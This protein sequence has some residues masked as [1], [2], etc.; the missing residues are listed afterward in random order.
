MCTL[1][2]HKR[3][4]SG[5]ADPL[6][7]FYIAC[8]SSI[9]NIHTHNFPHEHGVARHS[10]RL[11]C[12]HYMIYYLQKIHL[13]RHLKGWRGGIHFREKRKF[14]EGTLY[15]CKL[16]KNLT[17]VSDLGIKFPDLQMYQIGP[18]CSGHLTHL[19]PEIERQIWS[20]LIGLSNYIT[21]SPLLFF[22]RRSTLNLHII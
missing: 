14:F 2:Y 19:Y 1:L 12:R 4:G 3:S 13:A 10:A 8:S 6:Q 17:Q 15:P 22:E 5:V 20:R 21:N 9:L 11:R 18:L 16:F 7:V